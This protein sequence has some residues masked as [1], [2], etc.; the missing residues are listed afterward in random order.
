MCTSAPLSTVRVEPHTHLRINHAELSIVFAA[1]EHI[2]FLFKIAPKLPTL[3]MIVAMDDLEGEEKRV[4]S[5]WADSLGLKFMDMPEC[6]CLNLRLMRFPLSLRHSPQWKRLVERTS[7][8][9]FVLL[10]PMRL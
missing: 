5:A 8:M 1:T 9:S 6:L 10:R 2:P 3:K 4:L 7:S